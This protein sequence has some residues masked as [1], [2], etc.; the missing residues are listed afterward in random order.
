MNSLYSTVTFADASIEAK[1]SFMDSIIHRAEKPNYIKISKSRS[2]GV[3]K[4]TSLKE[5]SVKSLIKRENKINKINKYIRR[6]RIQQK[7]AKK[8]EKREELRNHFTQQIKK[9]DFSKL[10]EIYHF[11]DRQLQIGRA[12][13]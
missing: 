11:Q 13:V 9:L 10:L 6:L 8:Q 7:L 1:I 2:G 12:H 4:T 5:D 3:V